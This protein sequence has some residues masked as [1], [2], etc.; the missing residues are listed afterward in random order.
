MYTLAQ[1]DQTWPPL[2]FGDAVSDLKRYDGL[3]RIIYSQQAFLGFAN[4]LDTVELSEPQIYA[5]DREGNVE[6]EGNQYDNKIDLHRTN[7]IWQFVDNDFHNN[8]ALPIQQA[9]AFGLPTAV[10]FNIPTNENGV[11]VF[12]GLNFPH[13]EIHYSCDAPV[14]EGG[15]RK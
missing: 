4:H 9:N 8:N 10:N 3:G 11:T 14:K 6:G 7:R 1:Q 2:F 15:E 13:F 5:Y 12:F